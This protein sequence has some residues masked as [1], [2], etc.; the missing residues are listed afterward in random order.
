MLTFLRKYSI[1]VSIG[2]LLSI[3]FCSWQFPSAMLPLAICLLLFSLGVSVSSI[4]EKH[5]S[6]DPRSE[7]RRRVARDAGLL[8]LTS[9]FLLT[10]GG[11]AGQF[12]GD[13]VH[14]YTEGHGSGFGIILSFVAA[15][16]ASFTVGFI[17]RWAILRVTR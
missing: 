13:F 8:A 7:A 11:L 3:L 16:I 14:R 15:L 10:L 17:V 5:Q 6:V 9:I 2:L 12:A 1:L 4:L